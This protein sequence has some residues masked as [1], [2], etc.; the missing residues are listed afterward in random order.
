MPQGIPWGI[1]R[2]GVHSGEVIV[3]NFGGKTLL[4]YR[5]LGDPINAA[6]RLE[7]V[8]KQLGT[9]MCVSQE[10][11]D[12]C[13][14]VPARYVAR[15]VLKGKTKSLTVYEPLATADMSV[16]APLE[17]YSAAVN[18][19]RPGEAR[20]PVAARQQFER[21]AERYPKDPL[22]SLHLDRLRHGASDEEIIMTT[23]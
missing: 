23:K 19:L 10:I 11:L 12:S 3:G 7:S 9:R 5:A 2:I 6:A 16:C 17:D 8:N 4:D 18:L 15:L 22:V 1:T 20:D 14:P 21:L 13:P